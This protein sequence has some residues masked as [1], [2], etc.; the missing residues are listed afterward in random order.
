MERIYAR[1]LILAVLALLALSY[2]GCTSTS[3]K[4]QSPSQESTP[5]QEQPANQTPASVPQT[6]PPARPTE[7]FQ[8]GNLAPDFHFK[9]SDVQTVSLS[10]LRG[11]VVML[12]FWATWCGPCRFE[13]PFIQALYEDDKWSDKG[14]KILAI[15]NGESLSKVE[16]FVKDNGLS[17]PV[18]V[19]A[20]GIIAQAYNVRPLPTTF[21]IDKNGVIVEIRIGAFSSKSEIER[22]LSNIVG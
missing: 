3:V 10:D 6:E 7:G 21:F 19:D 15:N 11:N 13:I 8:K 9:I 2:S 16:R 14:L 22:I 17:F 1:A 4:P 20:R 5:H 18:L 12:N